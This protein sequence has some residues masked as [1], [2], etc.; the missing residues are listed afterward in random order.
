VYC[1]CLSLQDAIEVALD[2]NPSHH[3]A[4]F[5]VQAAHA[6]IGVAEAPYYPTY[7]FFADYSRFRQHIF[8]PRGFFSDLP[9]TSSIPSWVGP[10]NDYQILVRSRFTL[11]DSGKRRAQVQRTLAQR[12]EAL[13]EG[14][15]IRQQIILNVYL[16]FYTLLADLEIEKIAKEQVERSEGHLQ[17]A[18]HRK[19]AGDIPQAEV[20]RLEVE[21]ANA[22]Q[23]V[24]RAQTQVTISKGKLNLA[25]G[26]SPYHCIEIRKETSSIQ[27]PFEQILK[28]A[29]QQA[30]TH[31]PEL[32]ASWQRILAYYS[33]IK[34]VKS[35]FGPR[36]VAHGTYG[37]RD[38][39]FPPHDEDWR[40]GFSIEWPIFEGFS[41]TYQLRRVRA[42][43]QQEQAEF[44]QLYL[45]VQEDV[46]ES[47]LRLKEAYHLI[48]SIQTQIKS[49]RENLRLT[50]VRYQVGAGTLNDLLD[51]QIALTKVEADR[52]EAQW[53]YL[54]ALASFHWSQGTI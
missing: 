27:E 26:L 9:L 32:N 20:Y 38:E 1:H 17:I 48:L 11:Y 46:W 41:S 22:R 35:E 7:T 18:I 2:Q 6:A 28:E 52:T 14:Q 24:V 43:L 23:T 49:A 13:E 12:D 10:T 25:M 21:L 50:E 19:E 53:A 5:H 37:R 33:Q 45:Q 15:R 8:L 3:A 16:A 42:L 30:L 54:M 36:I 34:E 51:A 39:K 4:Q 47:F 29:F 31:R 44:E 40:V